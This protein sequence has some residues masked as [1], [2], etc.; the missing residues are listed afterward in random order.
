MTEK[1]YK[2]DEKKDSDL[3]NEIFEINKEMIGIDILLSSLTKKAGGLKVEERKWFEK[4]K[5]RHSIKDEDNEYLVYKHTTREIII[6][7][8]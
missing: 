2:L 3:I 7:K 8:Q 4:V 6:K 5:S 1:K